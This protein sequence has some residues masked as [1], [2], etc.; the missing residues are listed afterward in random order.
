MMNKLIYRCGLTEEEKQ[1]AINRVLINGE[2]KWAVAIDMA[3]LVK[4]F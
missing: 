2:A 1:E 3:F 4:E